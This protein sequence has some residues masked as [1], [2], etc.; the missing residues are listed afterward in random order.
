MTET[1]NK[2]G[3]KFTNITDGGAANDGE[4]VW[5]TL[6]F[7]EGQETFFCDYSLMSL[8]VGSLTQYASMADF[9]K[10]HSRAGEYVVTAPF[11]ITRVSNSGHSADGQ[12][13][14]VEF[15]TDRGF[16]IQVAMSPDHARATILLLERELQNTANAPTKGR[17]H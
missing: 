6:K 3:R 15:V 11:Q 2:Q 12:T 5:F 13:L 7:A 9:V 10:D 8:L 4:L 14:S 17:E 16:P 1:V